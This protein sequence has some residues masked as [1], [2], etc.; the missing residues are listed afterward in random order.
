MQRKVFG[1]KGGEV[2]K[3]WRKPL[4]EGLYGLYF[5]PNIIQVI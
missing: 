5:S 3:E 1:F 2:T 4:D